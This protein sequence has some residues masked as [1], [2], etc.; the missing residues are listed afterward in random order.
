MLDSLL[1]SVLLL[2]GVSSSGL[3]PYWASTNRYGLMPE[4]DGVLG[5]ASVKKEYNPARTWQWHAGVSLAGNFDSARHGFRPMVD[6]LYAGVKWKVLSLD[7]GMKRND[8]DF[9][10]GEMPFSLSTTGGSVVWSG[11]ARTMPGYTLTLIPWEVWKKHLWIEG[12]FGDYK[13]LDDR[14]VQGT[15]VH[16]TRMGLTFGITRRLRFG[17]HFN[18]YAMWAGTNPEYGRMPA[19]IGNYFRMLLGRSASTGGTASDIKN[20][21]G[22]QLGGEKFRLDWLGDGWKISFQHDIPY[23]DGSGM[24]FQNFPD[25]VNT[26]WFG[27]DDKDRWVSDMVYEFTSTMWQSGPRHDEYD[28]K[29]ELR[30][31]GGNDDYFNNTFYCSGWTLYGRVIGLPLFLPAGT[32]S[33][34]KVMG[35]VSNRIVSHHFGMAGKLFH[36]APYRL[37]L[38]GTSHFGRYSSPFENA[39]LKQFSFGLEGSVPLVSGRRRSLS[40]MYGIFG[41]C[42]DIYRNTFGATVG[43]CFKIY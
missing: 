10:A 43:L 35:I 37:M 28:S 25:G 13:T 39:P 15:L 41:D 20:V 11:N 17:V 16:N 14:Y 1:V 31:V 24:G 22:N 19:T 27:F 8:C 7:V 9:R 40:I 33:D 26:L 38:T 30:I 21:I 6:E 3:Q 2:G 12:A 4:G 23:D 5:L 32:D 34:G 29:G 36:K 42:G 18:H